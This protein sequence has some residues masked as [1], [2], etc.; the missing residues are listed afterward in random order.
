MAIFEDLISFITQGSIG[1]LPPIVLMIIPLI[2]GLVIGFFV[3][4][5]LKFALIAAV[6]VII[7]A[8]LGFYTLNLGSMVTLAEEYGPLAVQYGT[9]LIGMLPLGIG[10]VIGFIVGFLIAK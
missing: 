4:K 5:F 1:G 6:I 7:G 8:Y 10:L 2:I 9:I 3:N